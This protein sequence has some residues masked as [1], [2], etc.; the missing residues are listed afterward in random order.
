MTTEEY[1]SM[2]DSYLELITKILIE[3]GG[4]NPSITL[5]GV[6][7]EDGKTAIVHVPIPSKYMN[8]EEGKDEFVDDIV[9]QIADKVKKEFDINAVA[10]ASE[11]WLREADS[12]N[13]SKEE[14]MSSWKKLPIKKEVLIITIESEEGVQTTIKEILRKG[15]QVNE[16]G[17]LIDNVELID[18]PKFEGTNA[19]E[20][21]FTGLYKKFS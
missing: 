15:K 3:S 16:D 14:L 7:K 19:A 13:I 17:E 4:L 1:N 5:L 18:I 8:T 21:R 2:K 20:G 9:P 6:H 11:A 12:K 10:W